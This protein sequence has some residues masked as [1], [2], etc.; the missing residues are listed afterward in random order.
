ME[1]LI[2]NNEDAI[3][4]LMEAVRKGVP[5]EVFRFARLVGRPEPT[6]KRAWKEGRLPSAP[7]QSIPIREGLVALVSCGGL[8]RDGTPIPDFVMRAEAEARRLMGLSPRQTDTPSDVSDRD[9]GLKEWKLKYIK[10]QTA[11]KE[12]TAKAKEMENAILAGVYVKAD[13]V[14]LDAAEVAA[15]VSRVLKNLPDR[16]A[17]MCAGCT[18]QQIASIIRAELQAAVSMIKSSKFVP[19]KGWWE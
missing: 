18:P 17:G 3:N 10:A 1:D 2:A 11:A 14:E 8:R 9:S 19:D 7:N 15:G 4:E 12:A 16:V 13:D 6:I 5:V